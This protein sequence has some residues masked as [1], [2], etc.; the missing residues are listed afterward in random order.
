MSSLYTSYAASPYTMEC[1]EEQNA[2]ND[3]YKWDY[4]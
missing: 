3:A 2:K 1:R 4:S